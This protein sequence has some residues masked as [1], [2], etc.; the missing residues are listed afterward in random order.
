[1][2][3]TKIVTTPSKP[4][5]MSIERIGWAGFSATAN[6]GDDKPSPLANARRLLL[7]RLI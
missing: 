1:M 7:L 6:V 2:A 4:R 5:R 3:I